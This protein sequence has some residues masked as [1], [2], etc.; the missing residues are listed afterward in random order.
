MPEF[1][2]SETLRDNE[3]FKHW[4][5]ALSTWGNALVIGG[6][7]KIIVDLSLELGPVA[8]I[9]FGLAVPWMS[10]K[11]LTMLVAEGEI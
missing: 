3:P 6:F 4:S 2:R 5:G 8:A 1:S 9:L 11:I 10:S 7:G